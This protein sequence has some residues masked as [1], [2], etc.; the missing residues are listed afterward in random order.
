MVEVRGELGWCDNPL[1]GVA[2]PLSPDVV[3]LHLLAGAELVGHGGAFFGVAVVAAAAHESDTSVASWW[4]PTS[5]SH[6][7]RSL[8]MHTPC[9]KRGKRSDG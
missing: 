7:S 3:H 5:Q 2:I 8:L 1:L 6:F 4:Y 9:G